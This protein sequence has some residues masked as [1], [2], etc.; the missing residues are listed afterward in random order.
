MAPPATRGRPPGRPRRRRQAAHRAGATPDHRVAHGRQPAG[1]PPGHHDTGHREQHGQPGAHGEGNHQPG[2]RGRLAPPEPHEREEPINGHGDP[3]A[4][5]CREEALRAHHQAS[6]APARALDHEAQP[7]GR[8]SCLYRHV[9]SS[10]C[11]ILLRVDPPAGPCLARP[12]VLWPAQEAAARVWGYGALPAR[13]D[14]AS[15]R[16]SRARVL[17]QDSRRCAGTL[18]VYQ[19]T[20]AASREGAGSADAGDGDSGP[21]RDGDR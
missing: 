6:L 2:R 11:Q 12:C 20:S 5:P 10:C 15:L 14:D 18:R 3:A 19:D 9:R 1:G 4:T 16:I 13:S 17:D 7:S 21:G 8:I